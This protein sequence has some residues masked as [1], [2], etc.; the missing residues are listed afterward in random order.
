VNAD[1]NLAFKM[2]TKVE[3]VTRVASCFYNEPKFYGEASEQSKELISLA[4]AVSEKEPEFVFKL[5]GYCRNVLN[6][7]TVSVVLFVVA[8]NAESVKG[9][10]LAKAY[11]KSV[12]RRAD[13]IAEAIAFQLLLKGSKSKFPNNLRRSL[14]DRFDSF[15]EYQLSKYDSKGAV[16]L[17]DALR[18]LH[19][20]PSSKA[21]AKL[22]KSILDDSM[23]PADTWEVLISTKGSTKENWEK[24]AP[25]MGYMALIRNLRNFLEKEV[26]MKEVNKRIGDE[27]EVLKSKQLPFRFLS[28][29]REVSEV[30][31]PFT[32]NCLEAISKAA[33]VSVKN[34]PELRGVT[35]LLIDQSGSM[36][37]PVSEKSKVSRRD[38]AHVLAAILNEQC[39]ATVT[40]G[41]SESAYA[42]NVP[43]T[44]VISTVEKLNSEFEGGGTN[45][46]AAFDFIAS[47]KVRADRIVILTDQTDNRGYASRGFANYKRLFP[48]VKL[49]VVDLT[50]YG[51]SQ[52]IPDKGTVMLG[53]FSEKIFNFINLREQGYDSMVKEIEKYEFEERKEE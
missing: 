44:G 4:T 8:A 28:A 51:T 27:E 7:R 34:V 17:K 22:Y 52:F 23:K 16:K 19:P 53:G 40:I 9:K 10:G 24:I 2:P 1:G 30:V 46:E 47:K 14:A 15:S 37:D 18:I 33:D 6:L 49:Y 32:R 45:T 29:Y 11:A 26:N 42:L 21:R 20:K 39:S 38:A 43:R 50:G 25:K 35:A 48:E 3:L 41:F 31:N 36:T 13:E 12:I 5:A